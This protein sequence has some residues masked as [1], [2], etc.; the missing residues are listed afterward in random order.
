[1]GMSAIRKTALKIELLWTPRLM[2]LSVGGP[3]PI[4]LLLRPAKLEIVHPFVSVPKY[5]APVRVYVRL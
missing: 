4:R 5:L 3:L 2:P 1:M